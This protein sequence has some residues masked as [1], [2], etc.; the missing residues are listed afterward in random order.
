MAQAQSQRGNDFYRNSHSGDRTPAEYFLLNVK[1]GRN[2]FPVR[3]P[4]SYN[5]N[6]SL[7]HLNVMLSRYTRGRE[8]ETPC[9]QIEP[10]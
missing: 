1:P 3:L 5:S 6:S 8:T 2:S 7:L 10:R 4:A 9:R